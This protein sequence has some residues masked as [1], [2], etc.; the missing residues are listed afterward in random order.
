MK[1]FPEDFYAYL[2]ENT[3]IEIKG[4]DQRKTFLKI[5]MVVVNNRV[6]ARSWNKSKKSWFTE[7]INVGF[8]QIRQG[9]KIINVMGKKVN[10]DDKIHILIDEAYLIKYSQNENLMYAKGISTPEFYNFTMEFFVDPI[11]SA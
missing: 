6:F 8:G 10:K 4:G 11:S 5:C 1:I 3:L 2:K 7:F 9:E